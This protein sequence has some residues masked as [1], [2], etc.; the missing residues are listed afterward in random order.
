MK[1]S[2]QCDAM[3]HDE[4][5]LQIKDF[6]SSRDFN[7]L[8][9]SLQ[10]AKTV[11]VKF[12]FTEEIEKEYDIAKLAFTHKVPNFIKFFC[13]FP[14]ND[15]VDSI[16]QRNFLVNTQ[17]CN[18]R[19]DQQ[20]GMIMMPYYPLG[21]LEK[22]RWNRGNFYILK[23]VL[24]Q[25]VFALLYAYEQ[26]QMVHG[27]MHVGNVLL[28]ASKKKQVIYGTR[29]LPVCGLYPL[30]MDFGR[31][32][33]ATN[34]Y[35]HVYKNIDRL[36]VLIQGMENSDLALECERRPLVDLI[37]SNTPIDDSVYK[38]LYGVIENIQIRYVASELPSF[39]I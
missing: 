33:V 6:L 26:F 22:Y 4:T 5:W 32:F 27:D 15:T 24:H 39:R 3:K 37:V 18:G 35:S 20:L 11:V 34:A 19:P 28:R 17:I 14:C 8:L 2:L 31:S 30:V 29:S 21:N 25:T 1:F 7:I 23:N 10:N 13:M 36:L 38:T 9:G 16:K 12:G